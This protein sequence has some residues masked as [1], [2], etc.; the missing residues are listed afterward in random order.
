[1]YKNRWE[2]FRV[3]TYQVDLNAIKFDAELTKFPDHA[4]ISMYRFETPDFLLGTRKNNIC[5]TKLIYSRIPK[6]PL[7][8]CRH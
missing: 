7:S 2:T 1:M 4:P 6:Y 8:P 3:V 5:E